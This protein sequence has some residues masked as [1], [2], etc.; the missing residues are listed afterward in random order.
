MSRY[1]PP[2]TSSSRQNPSWNPWVARSRSSDPDSTWYFVP[3]PMACVSY[4]TPV[5]G[6]ADD[7]CTFATS[8]GIPNAVLFIGAQSATSRAESLSSSGSV[9]SGSV[10][11]SESGNPSSVVPSQSL[12]TPSHVSAD[13]DPGVQDWE[14]PFMQFCTVTWQAPTPHVVA[15]SSSSVEPSQSLSRLSHCSGTGEPG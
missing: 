14:F 9:Q 8:Y 11:P 3:L 13:P 4:W 10:S 15:P 12:S 2:V 5:C 7:T 6:P 1:S